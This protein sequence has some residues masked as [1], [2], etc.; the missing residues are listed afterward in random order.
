MAKNVS[1]LIVGAGSARGLFSNLNHCNIPTTILTIGYL[2]RVILRTS[3]TRIRLEWQLRKLGIAW[4]VMVLFV[5]LFWCFYC[6]NTHLLWHIVS[7]IIFLNFICSLLSILFIGSPINRRQKRNILHLNSLS[8]VIPRPLIGRSLLILTLHCDNIA[9]II[10]LW[11]LLQ[12]LLYC[13]LIQLI[14]HDGLNLLLTE[15]VSKTKLR[16]RWR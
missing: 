15:I 13:I 3:I 9:S 6:I 8:R 14:S 5:P 4:S 12:H 1:V 2:L 11:L 16:H 10:A 7:T